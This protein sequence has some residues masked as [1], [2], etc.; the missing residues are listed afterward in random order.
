M[1]KRLQKT[2]LGVVDTQLRT[3][4]PPEVKET[5]K[6]LRKMKYSDKEARLLI[7]Q[8]LVEE[9]YGMM[10]TDQPHDPSR[11]VTALNRLPEG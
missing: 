2:I 10:A 5:Y 9:I 6:R 3:K 11:Y 7:A 4:N 1:S 8:A